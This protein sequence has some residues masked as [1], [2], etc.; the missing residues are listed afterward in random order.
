MESSLPDTEMSYAAYAI[1]AGHLRR[2]KVILA[3]LVNNERTKWKPICEERI[4][5]GIKKLNKMPV[6]FTIIFL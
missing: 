6:V 4:D 1:V 5:F 2:I 3:R